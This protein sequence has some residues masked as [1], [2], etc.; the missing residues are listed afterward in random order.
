MYIST[1]AN[2]SDVSPLIKA[3]ELNGY[4][5]SAL[6]PYTLNQASQSASI[7][8]SQGYHYFEVFHQNTGGKNHLSVAVETPKIDTTLAVM[9]PEIQLL[10]YSPA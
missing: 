3:V 5:P 9:G 4:N 1:T 6:N 10:A 7:L 8:L 2:S